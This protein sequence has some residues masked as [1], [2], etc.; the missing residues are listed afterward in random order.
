MSSHLVVACHDHPIVT[1]GRSE[2]LWREAHFSRKPESV[3]FC[4]EVCLVLGV[5]ECGEVLC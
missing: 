1:V 4:N 3:A 2:C 5:L